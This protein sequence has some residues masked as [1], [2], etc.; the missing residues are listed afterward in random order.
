MP[1]PSRRNDLIE[2]AQTLFNAE[3]FHAVGIERILSEGNLAKMTLYRHFPS[4]NALILGVLEA[5]EKAVNG[6]FREVLADP[7]LEGKGRLLAIFD[8]LEVWFEN[9]SPLG[10]F[11]G[12]LF[13]RASGEFPHPTDPVH[14]AAADAKQAFVEMVA[15]AA[16]LERFKKPRLLA[17]E[18]TLLKEG[19]I[20]L[21]QIQGASKPALDAKNAAERL[22]ADW[23]RKK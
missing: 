22:L 5:R 12:C 15:A 16:E 21:A 17:R 8:A 1:R 13:V 10:K 23:P 20:A 7:N 9:R 18:L 3:G 14:L 6:W 2:T 11:S 19:A 4:K